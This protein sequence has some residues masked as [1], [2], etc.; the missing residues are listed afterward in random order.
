L[1]FCIDGLKNMPDDDRLCH[2]DFHPLNVLG[3]ASQPFVIDW[4]D[5]CRGDPTG[6]VCRSYL[7]LKFHADGICGAISRCLLPCR[8]CPAP[9]D[10]RLDGVRRSGQTGSPPPRSHEERGCQVRNGLSAGAKRIRTP[11]PALI[12]ML[13]PGGT[14][15]II[16]MVPFGVKIELHGYDLLS[17]R[18]LQGTS[19]G[20]TASGSTC[21][22]SCHSGA[23]AAHKQSALRRSGS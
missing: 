18:K 12:G 16:G 13:R 6:D 3:E 21:R 20:A 23:R 19:M 22:A 5:A 10:P 9:H 4:P 11:G 7:L 17:D 8:R 14:A 2:G 15:T 1:A